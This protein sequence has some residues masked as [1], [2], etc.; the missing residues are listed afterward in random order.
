LTRTAIDATHAM[1][2]RRETGRV[3]ERGSGVNIV[4]N[5]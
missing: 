2:M 4:M 3:T 1:T 5:L